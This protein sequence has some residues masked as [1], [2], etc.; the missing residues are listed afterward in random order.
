MKIKQILSILGLSVLLWSG[1]F[2]ALAVY[3][4]NTLLEFQNKI[5]LNIQ[6]SNNRT[7]QAINNSIKKTDQIILTPHIGGMTIEAQE[8]AYNHATS[9]LK[10]EISLLKK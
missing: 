3:H 10:K 7:D 4:D 2:V 6:D 1:G 8:L 5:D 9:I